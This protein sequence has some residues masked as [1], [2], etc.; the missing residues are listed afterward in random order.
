M[1]GLCT[2]NL[3]V[4][5]LILEALLAVY[6]GL[7]PEN[8]TADGELP[9]SQ[10]NRRYNELQRQLRGLQ[11]AFGREVD[12][13]EVYGWYGSKNAFLAERAKQKTA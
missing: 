6:S 12:E 4:D 13:S 1:R 7:S 5:N 11:T 10:V 8:L 9:R 2:R 3:T